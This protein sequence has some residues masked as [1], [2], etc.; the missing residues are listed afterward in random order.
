MLDFE[1][2]LELDPFPLPGLEFLP[3]PPLP[4]FLP[5]NLPILVSMV[6]RLLFFVYGTLVSASASLDARI[7]VRSSLRDLGVSNVSSFL[8]RDRRYRGL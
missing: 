2:F 7:S 8:Y 1:L 4:E 6:Y 3:L 5:W